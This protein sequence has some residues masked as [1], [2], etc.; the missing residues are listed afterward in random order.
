MEEQWMAVADKVEVLTDKH[1]KLKEENEKLNKKVSHLED[2]MAYLEGQSKRNNLVFHGL[3]EKRGET[4]DKMR[5]SS[6]KSYRGKP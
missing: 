3:Q 2:N 4:W 6:K 5:G 1:S